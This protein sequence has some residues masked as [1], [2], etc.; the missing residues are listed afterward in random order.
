MKPVVVEKLDILM[1]QIIGK[2]ISGLDI[3]ITEK[4]YDEHPSLRPESLE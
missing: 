2:I 1:I 3:N 4:I